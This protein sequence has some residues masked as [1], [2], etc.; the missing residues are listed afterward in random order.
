MKCNRTELNPESHPCCD[1][2]E[3]FELRTSAEVSQTLTK[4]TR[5]RKMNTKKISVEDMSDRD[6]ALK[7][8]L[9]AWRAQEMKNIGFSGK[10]FFG[11]QFVMSE[12][13]LQRIIELAHES[14]L[15]NATVFVEQV[16]WCDSQIYADEILEI[17][18]N[19]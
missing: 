18:Q 5:K 16:Q 6:N 10:D 2:C 7:D 11:P 17:I 14:K 13:I 19:V 12:R 15:T 9:V 8:A 3:P 4:A 1:T